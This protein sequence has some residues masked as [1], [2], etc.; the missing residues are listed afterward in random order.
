MT[1]L[2]RVPYAG[3]QVFG[4]LARRAGGFHVRYPRDGRHVEANLSKQ[5]LAEIEPRGRVRTIYTM[6]S[7]KP[8]TPTVVGHFQV[9]S[10]TPGVNSEGMVDSNYFIRGYAIHGYPEVPTYAASHGCLR[11]P[12]PD[13]PAIYAWVQTGTPVDVYDDYGGGSRNVSSHAGP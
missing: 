9:Y 5:V 11:V 13:A 3:G 6:S 12:I 4:L 2:A 10:K 1:G 8:S 7:G